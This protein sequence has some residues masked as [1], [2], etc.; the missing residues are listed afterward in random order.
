MPKSFKPIV[1]DYSTF[2][3]EIAE[4]EKFLAAN[5]DELSEQG[6]ISPFFKGHPILS[7]Q[8]ASLFSVEMPDRIVFEYDIFGDF[9]C[10]L[11]IGNSGKREYCFVEFEDARAQSLFKDETKFK[12]SFGLRLEHGHSQI[13]DWFYKIENLQGTKE[14][15][16]RFDTLEID[17]YGVLIIG[18][19][20]F[21]N[22]TLRSR[23]DWR[24]DNIIIKQKSINIVT[25]DD[26]LTVFKTKLGTIELYRK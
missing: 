17:Y 20:K 6:D 21:L 13:I 22:N 19:N 9:R 24:S 18:R 12:P 2:K 5:P 25:F 3:R 1:F 15:L 23:L 7:S 14:M 11:A 8:I 16:E 26:L 4:Y 10:D